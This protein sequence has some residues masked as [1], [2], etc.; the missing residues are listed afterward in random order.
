MSMAAKTLALVLLSASAASAQETYP[1]G[2]RVGAWTP[3][4]FFYTPA[5]IQAMRERLAKEPKD[6]PLHHKVGQ[7]RGWLGRLGKPGYLERL[8]PE[9]P[10]AVW[11]AGST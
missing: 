10:G 3:E 7:G 5:D 2:M 9:C 11:S 1:G 8:L 6:G 4:E